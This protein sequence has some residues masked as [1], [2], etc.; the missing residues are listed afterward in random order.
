MRLVNLSKK[1]PIQFV[2]TK[3]DADLIKQV[4]TCINGAAIRDTPYTAAHLLS[5][6]RIDGVVTQLDANAARALGYA[7]KRLIE[8][9]DWYVTPGLQ[10]FV[11]TH[12]AD[13]DGSR[14]KDMLMFS[15]VPGFSYD[16]QALADW[17]EQLTGQGVDVNT[18][19]KALSRLVS[20]GKYVRI[21]QGVYKNLTEGMRA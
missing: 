2:A 1:Y 10:C 8:N 12:S 11:K 18:V 15:V 9:K 13:Q 4:S 19:R 7:M 5:Q 20:E 3:A 17:L 14:V 21:M 16:A 6:L